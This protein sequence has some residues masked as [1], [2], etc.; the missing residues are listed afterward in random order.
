MGSKTLVAQRLM[1]ARTGSPSART[2]SLTLETARDRAPRAAHPLQ[3]SPAKQ[4][5]DVKLNGAS[6]AC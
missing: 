1:R 3:S 5:E 2:L 4:E 6:A